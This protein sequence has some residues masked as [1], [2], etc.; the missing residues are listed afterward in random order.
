MV[1]LSRAHR[2]V[3]R[4][5]GG[6]VPFRSPLGET[7]DVEVLEV[8]SPTVSQLDVELPGYAHHVD[9]R[10]AE[11]PDVG[12]KWTLTLDGIDYE[13]I[14]AERLKPKGD[15]TRCYLEVRGEQIA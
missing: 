10:T 2:A 15:I 1:D 7:T 6:T 8:R 13:V 14:D 12:E 3:A 4:H 9:I 11:H 5:F